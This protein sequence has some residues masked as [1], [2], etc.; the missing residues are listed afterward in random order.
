MKCELKKRMVVSKNWKQNPIR[1]NYCPD[2][3]LLTVKYELIKRNVV[4]KN[5]K[6]IPVVTSYC[7]RK[8]YYLWSA[9]KS[10]RYRYRLLPWERSITRKV[11]VDKEKRCSKELEADSNRSF[12]SYAGGARTSCH[13]R[14]LR[15]CQKNN[16]TITI[17]TITTTKTTTTT[18]RTEAT[19]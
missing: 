10:D 7:T 12:R 2:K 3:S 17:I 6:Q 13:D 19:T 14:L 8:V 16:K 1:T 11:W 15:Y 4:P 9:S 5:W 18:I